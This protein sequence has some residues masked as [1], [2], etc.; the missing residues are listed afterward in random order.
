ML[1]VY[2]CSHEI[3]MLS[4]GTVECWDPRSLSRVGELT[5][6]SADINFSLSKYASVIG[7][8]DDSA[9]WPD[10][11]PDAF[12]AVCRKRVLPACL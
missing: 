3:V 9:C 12:T 1:H 2:L 8:G 10:P 4:Q 5:L 11:L 7:A 6:A